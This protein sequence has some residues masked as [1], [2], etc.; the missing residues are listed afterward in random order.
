VEGRIC[1]EAMLSEWIRPFIDPAIRAIAM[2]QETLGPE[3]PDPCTGIPFVT[4]AAG[5]WPL[6]AGKADRPT[7]VTNAIAF[8]YAAAPAE[9][10]PPATFLEVPLE[11][12]RPA[13][14]GYGF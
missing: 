12:L 4:Y 9:L 8:D 13:L 7:L 14:R 3:P 10:T 5:G 11:E 6:I 1:A 2:V